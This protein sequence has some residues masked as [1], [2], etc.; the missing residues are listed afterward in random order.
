MVEAKLLGFA[1][2]CLF[3]VCAGYSACTKENG[4]PLH[5]S[6][7]FMP[8]RGH[9]NPILGLAQ[10][11]AENGC[12][13]TFPISA[14]K[15]NWVDYGGVEVLPIILKHNETDS[16]DMKL[17]KVVSTRE[18]GV[19]GILGSLKN[20]FTSDIVQQF[21]NVQAPVLRYVLEEHKKGNYNPDIVV[22]EKMCMLCDDAARAIDVPVVSFQPSLIQEGRVDHYVPAF[23]TGF[24]INMTTTQRFLNQLMS[25]V[26]PRLIFPLFVGGPLH[27]TREHFG[28]LDKVPSYG[29]IVRDDTYEIVATCFGFDHPRPILPLTKLVGPLIPKHMKPIDSDI[30]EWL[31]SEPSDVIY[32]CMGTVATITSEMA[33]TLVKAMGDREYRVL[34]ALPTNQREIID[35]ITIPKNFRLEDFVPQREILQHRKIKG[36]VSHTGASSA[37][38]AMLAEVPVVCMPFF[39]D[40]NDYCQRIVDLGAGFH[41]DKNNL[42]EN[43]I[44]MKVNSILHDESVHK[45]VKRASKLLQCGGTKAAADIVFEMYENGCD[46]LIPADQLLEGLQR[47]GIDVKLFEIALIIS[48]FCIIVSGLC[49]CKCCM[50][51]MYRKCCAKKI[52]PKP[53]PAMPKHTKKKSKKRKQN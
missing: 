4:D 11:L 13:V 43:D 15:T 12:K 23:G 1:F 8:L 34:W 39:G 48:I 16:M 27:D 21:L 31:E 7:L 44:Q 17:R 14:N 26:S 50:F 10:D 32:M 47:S 9:V 51:S 49:C 28:I 22:T 40:Q 19:K 20:S 37:N 25:I 30:L 5:V 3:G 29:S 53:L 45:S 36:F 2:L 33:S 6:F 46:H 38:E 24:P 42:D 35:S 41:L 52:S 18:P